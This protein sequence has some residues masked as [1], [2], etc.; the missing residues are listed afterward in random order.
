[1]AVTPITHSSLRHLQFGES[2]GRLEDPVNHELAITIFKIVAIALIAFIVLPTLSTAKL[3]SSLIIFSFGLVGAGCIFNWGDSLYFLF[4]R[5]IENIPV[6][7]AGETR[8][9]TTSSS[10]S[11]NPNVERAYSLFHRTASPDSETTVNE[12]ETSYSTSS[13]SPYDSSDE[14]HYESP[15]EDEDSE[16]ERVDSPPPSPSPLLPIREPGPVGTRHGDFMA[17]GE[18]SAFKAISSSPA[19]TE[20]PS[21][22]APQTKKRVARRV[23]FADDLKDNG[24]ISPSPVT[25]GPTSDKP[26]L[27][28]S[29]GNIALVDYEATSRLHVSEEPMS[30]ESPSTFS[31]G[32]VALDDHEATS[33][34]HV[35]EGPMPDD[36]PSAFSTGNVALEERGVTNHLHLTEGPMS[37]EPPSAFS[38]A[39]ITLE[40]HGVRTPLPDSSDEE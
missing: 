27:A 1:M 26:P 24:A 6:F 31:T 11:A 14:V 35:T 40:E 19:T 7:S 4:L 5:A 16:E 2:R 17:G 36:S 39:N 3:V 22:D 12:T 21:T 15:K 28:F 18:R 13:T 32:N 10:T 33:R 38:T 20:K 37:D 25:E 9:E 29:T 30:D 23:R 8:T 34:L